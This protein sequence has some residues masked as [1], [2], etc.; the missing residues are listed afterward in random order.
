MG[1]SQG[2]CRGL[3][4]D[5]CG[6]RWGLSSCNWWE[7]TLS[8]NGDW[9]VSGMM[10]WVRFTKEAR[11]RR[12]RGGRKSTGRRGPKGSA[13]HFPKVRW[14]RMQWATSPSALIRSLSVQNASRLNLAGL[15]RRP[16]ALGFD[17]DPSTAVQIS[18]VQACQGRTVHQD[19]PPPP[20]MNYFTKRDAR[21][22]SSEAS[23]SLAPHTI[24]PPL[25]PLRSELEAGSQPSP[26][27]AAV[28]YK[29]QLLDFTK[30]PPRPPG[31]PVI[32]LN[33]LP[34]PSRFRVINPLLL[35]SRSQ[36]APL[37][38]SRPDEGDR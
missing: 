15:R 30:L 10:S 32:P 8:T 2:D 38:P 31:C 20:P 3:A 14:Y 27:F 9:T 5:Y 37:T 21:P 34:L 11:W 28:N 23:P 35:P 25:P 33:A 16:P 26:T 17:A 6:S 36:H 4:V 18:N 1:F 7:V 19:N 13:E 22:P 29:Q 12:M 24:R